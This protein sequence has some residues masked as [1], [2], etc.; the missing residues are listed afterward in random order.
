MGMYYAD[1]NKVNGF[2]EVYTGWG[3]EDSD[4]AVRLINAGVKRKDARYSVPVMHMWHQES[5]RSALDKNTELLDAVI[6]R[7][8]ISAKKGLDQ[9]C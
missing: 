3:R 5:D 2:D 9:Y 6:S 1:I 4:F 8:T 7:K